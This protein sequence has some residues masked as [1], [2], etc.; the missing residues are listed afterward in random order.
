MIRTALLFLLLLLSIF[1]LTAATDLHY[2]IDAETNAAMHN[3]LGLRCLKEKYFFGAIKEFQ[4]ALQLNP[5]TQSSAVYYN[6]LGRTYII[7]GY[8]ELAENNFRNAIKKYPLNFEYYLN[9]IDSY[10]R[11]D[12]I[13]EMLNYH[14]RNRK[15]NLD[16][17]IIALLYGQLGEKKTEITMLDEFCNNE[18]NLIITSAI[19]KYIFS[20]TKNINY[21]SN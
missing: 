9:L 16:D 10:S 8:P 14:K 1:T 13:E 7:I 18:P 4:I 6:N 19:K 5:N 20:K 2:V 21:D 12:K 11:Q 17:I 15:N 3:N